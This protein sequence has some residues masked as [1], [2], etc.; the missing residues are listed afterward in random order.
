MAALKTHLLKA[1]ANRN[2]AINQH[3][4]DSLRLAG[5]AATAARLAVAQDAANRAAAAA[6]NVSPKGSTTP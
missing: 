4:A 2:K 5:Q 3:K 1:L 6:G